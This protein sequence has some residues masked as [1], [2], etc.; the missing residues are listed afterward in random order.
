MKAQGILLILCVS[1][2]LL[3]AQLP[4]PFTKL[5]TEIPSTKDIE[6]VKWID[7]LAKPAGWSPAEAEILSADP[8]DGHAAFIFHVPVDHF[9]G[10]PKYPIGWPRAY[11]GGAASINWKDY[12]AFQFKIYTKMNRDT[13]PKKAFSLAFR[14][15]DKGKNIEVPF[16]KDNLRLNEWTTFTMPINRLAKLPS[17]HTIGFYVC[18]SDFNHGDTLDFTFGG[19]RLIRS[20]AVK[21]TS[22][23][24][25]GISYRETPALDVKV[26]AEGSSSTIG[27]GVP[28]ALTDATGKLIRLETLPV[29]RGINEIKM[30][31]SELRLKPGDYQLTAFPKEAEKTI[32]VGFKIVDSPW[33]VKK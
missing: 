6:D 14:N 33:E 17:I 10:E 31:V 8:V 18:E 9:A 24:C 27:K 22:L 1:M 2:A 25:N 28:F 5:P 19:F 20:S 29:T 4:P 26:T 23:E 30:D 13:L 11:F 12:D 21:I 3:A 16:G 32:R 15:P 7:S